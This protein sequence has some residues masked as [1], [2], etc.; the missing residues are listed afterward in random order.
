MRKESVI[1]L[2]TV[3]KDIIPQPNPV[4]FWWNGESLLI[5]SQSSGQKIRNINKVA[6][7]FESDGE[8]GN[9]VILN[10]I[11]SIEEGLP[12]TDDGSSYLSKYPDSI[13]EL[14][15]DINSFA[16]TYSVP[17]RVK[18]NNLRGH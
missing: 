11:A 1:W 16:V 15:M 7:H 8:G 17:I 5:F 14:G 18:L 4:W 13:K 3:R 12:P 6:L 9:I 10:G 2:V